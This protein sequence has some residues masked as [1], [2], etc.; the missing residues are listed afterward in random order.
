MSFVTITAVFA[1]EKHQKHQWP[2]TEAGPH[3]PTGVSTEPSQRISEQLHRKGMKALCVLVIWIQLEDSRAGVKHWRTVLWIQ[4]YLLCRKGLVRRQYIYVYCLYMHERILLKIL[5]NLSIYGT[6]PENEADS[7]P[8]MS[9]TLF[10]SI[11]VW[12]VKK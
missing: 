5:T 12:L 3:K 1:E 4:G 8:L 6:G 2:S 7:K 10:N 11:S 9:F